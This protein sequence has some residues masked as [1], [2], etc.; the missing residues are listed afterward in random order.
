MRL[1]VGDRLQL[2]PPPSIGGERCMVKL[3]GYVEGNTLIVGAPP[4][5]QWMPPLAEGDPIEIRVFSSQTAFGFTVYV[6]K[7]IKQPFEYLHL[8][9]PKN[10][11]GKII[12]KSRRVKTNIAVEIAD[13]PV[14]ATISNL[15]V[16]GAE[17]Y[18]SASLGQLGTGL[19]ISFTVQIHGI[20][21]PLS[22]RATIASMS[23]DLDIAES[24]MRYGVEFRN[25]G[26]EQFAALQS[27]I[28]QELVE[29]PHNVV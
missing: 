12:R 17:L 3:I 29:H 23:H 11:V 7:I 2:N 25:L 14:P 6:D 26:A 1:N 4:S 27:L 16:T 18:A 22:L 19:G 28:Y 10:I 15:S 21:T 20:E 9:F 8:S 5:G 24:A 13:N